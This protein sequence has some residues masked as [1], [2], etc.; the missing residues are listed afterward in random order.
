M[1]VVA[2]SGASLQCQR[3]GQ[4]FEDGVH[5]PSFPQSLVQRLDVD[6][7]GYEVGQQQEEVKT[8]EAWERERRGRKHQLQSWYL[9]VVRVHVGFFWPAS[10]ALKCS[11]GFPAESAFNSKTVKLRSAWDGITALSWRDGREAER[12]DDGYKEGTNDSSR[13]QTGLH[14]ISFQHLIFQHVD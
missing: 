13:Y 11:S 3:C 7:A 10:S 2:K 4:H 6:T 1:D 5:G 14:N 9:T 12:R 8:L